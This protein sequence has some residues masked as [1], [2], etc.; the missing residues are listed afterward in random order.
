MERHT[1]LIWS[2]L[3]ASERS[4]PH[5]I[6]DWGSESLSLNPGMKYEP[7]VDLTMGCVACKCLC[8]TNG[9]VD[10]T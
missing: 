8:S 1:V 9:L 4:I 2:V 5:A 7:N 3:G 10:T 6:W